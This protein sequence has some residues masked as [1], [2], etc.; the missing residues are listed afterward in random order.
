MIC[1]MDFSKFD[2]D[3]DPSWDKS[4][5]IRSIIDV[6]F[7]IRCFFC[8]RMLTK[9]SFNIF[10][11]YLHSGYVTFC[12]GW[13][14]IVK[15][16]TWNWG[17]LHFFCVFVES[18]EWAKIILLIFHNTYTVQ[19]L[20]IILYMTSPFV[21]TTQTIFSDSLFHFGC[22]SDYSECDYKIC[23]SQ[24]TDNIDINRGR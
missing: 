23:C 20:T 17:Q 12:Q 2:F 1:F 8:F 21:Y 11:L 14:Q 24:Q 22:E 13:R 6:D 18:S 5:E 3:D 15:I 19:S 10:F 7:G 9:R 4:N 16:I